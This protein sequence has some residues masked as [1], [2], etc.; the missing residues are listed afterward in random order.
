M[1]GCPSCDL[2]LTGSRMFDEDTDAWAVD[3][4]FQATSNPRSQVL[5]ALYLISAKHLA[6]RKD[7]VVHMCLWYALL[8]VAELCRRHSAVIR[9][10]APRRGIG[11]G[12]DSGDLINIGVHSKLGFTPP[13]FETGKRRRKKRR[14]LP[15]DYFELEGGPQLL[16]SNCIDNSLPKD[17]F[18][19]VG[20]IDLRSLYATIHPDWPNQQGT[21]GLLYPF[22]CYFVSASFAQQIEAAFPNEVQ[23]HTL[24]IA[25]RTEDWRLMKIMHC[26]NC[27]DRDE[28]RRQYRLTL[29]RKAAAGRNIFFVAGYYEGLAVIVSRPVAQLFIDQEVVG[30][31]FVPIA[32]I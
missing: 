29:S 20:S 27:Y 13:P 16:M 3:H 18:R 22:H 19:V 25:G 31:E 24:K 7:A 23:F 8:A 21:L 9:G 26:V 1:D 17:L 11:V 15:A 14:L 2:Y 4:S 28:S 12:F 6:D 10:S 5:D 30:A 32:T